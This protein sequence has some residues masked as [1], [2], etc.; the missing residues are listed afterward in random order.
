MNFEGQSVLVTGAS[1]GIGKAIALGFAA[2]GANVA[3]NYAGSREKAEETALQC[4]EHGVKT[5]V[6]Q[7]DVSSESDVKEMLK[8]VTEEF[9]G[10]DVL[11]NNAGIT[12]DNLLMRMKE[13]EWDDVIDTN[14]KSVFLTSRAAAR[15]MMKKRGG[16]IINMASVV[17]TTGNPGQANYTA[18]KAGVVGLT[19]TLARE[20]AS[21]NIRVNAVAPGFIST[22]MTDELE[23]G[24]KEQ[25]MQQIPLQKLGE[26]EDVAN[27]VLFLASDS[28]KYMT[29][30]TLHVDGG[31]VMP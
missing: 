1:R 27:T 10:I 25:M 12:K 11:I 28:A 31:M 2:Q 3:I 24:A 4:G 26:T 19:K 29:G 13:D 23:E 8:Q 20:L 21:R 22:E 7:A 9:G 6:I 16:T 18:S 14:L 17:G 15:P 30:Q 5:L